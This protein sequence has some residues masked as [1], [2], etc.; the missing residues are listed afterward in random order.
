[1]KAILY[2]NGDWYGNKGRIKRR[3]GKFHQNAEK[4][5]GRIGKASCRQSYKKEN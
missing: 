1:M 3:T 5:R 2:G 4:I